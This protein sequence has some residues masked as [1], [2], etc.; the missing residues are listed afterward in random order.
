MNSRRLALKKMTGMALGAAAVTLIPKKSFAA[1]LSVTSEIGRNHGHA[2]ALT[3]DE[4]IL[5]TR[6]N[7]PVSFDIQGRSGHPHEVT[8]SREQLLDLIV[9]GQLS[10]QS[11][12]DAGHTHAVTIKLI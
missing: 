11:S 12:R 7:G 9:D 1:D 4:V 8:L 10:V 3:V 5:A 6:E 2:L